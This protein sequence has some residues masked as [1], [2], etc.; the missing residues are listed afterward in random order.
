MHCVSPETKLVR[1]RSEAELKEAAGEDHH[2][3]HDPPR[4]TTWKDRPVARGP[5]D[6]KLEHR[7]RD[8]RPVVDDGQPSETHQEDGLAGQF[9]ALEERIQW[10]A[11]ARDPQRG[12]GDDVD[13]DENHERD[14]RN[15][16]DPCPGSRAL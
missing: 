10:P 1:A 16:R 15:R 14:A 12:Q 13:H 11:R 7:D 8:R 6:S 2:V 4:N 3:Q 5:S 9:G